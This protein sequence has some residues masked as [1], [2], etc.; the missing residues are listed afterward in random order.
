MKTFRL[1]L[2]INL[3]LSGF[4]AN[5]QTYFTNSTVYEPIKVCGIQEVEGIFDSNNGS[6][7]TG[8]QT[9]LYFSFSPANSFTLG[10]GLTLRYDLYDISTGL[11]T[12]SSTWKIYGPFE[13]NDDYTTMISSNYA[14]VLSSG[15]PATGTIFFTGNIIQDKFYIVEVIANACA[16]KLNFG[17]QTADFPCSSKKVVCTDCIPKFQPIENK[18][19]V[20]AWVR[21][22]KNTGNS[23]GA[24]NYSSQLKVTSGVLPSVTFTPS[25][26][27]IDGWQRIEGVITTNS[28]G[29]LKM[30]LIVTDNTITA[31]YDDIR[32]FPYDGSMV[33]YVYDPAT[34]RLAAELDERNYAK[35][36]EYD[37]EGKLIRVKKETEKGIMTIQENRE[38]SAK[39]H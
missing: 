23:N 33:T 30:E 15:G 10:S 9:K 11:S 37:E 13:P 16:A 12:V 36:Y 24:L 20:S 3:L 2:L 5:A 8:G 21:E 29:N 38:N 28:V 18:Y 35:I 26:Q 1:I 14:P 6:V 17:S 25:G 19:V 34:L 22:V 32:V 39:E 31:Y 7:C 4:S 27:I